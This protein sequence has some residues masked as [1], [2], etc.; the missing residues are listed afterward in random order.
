[1]DLQLDQDEAGQ[2]IRVRGNRIDAAG[3]VTF[4]DRVLTLVEGGPGR[5]MLDLSSI[6]FLDSSGLGALVAIRRML[7]D[8]ALELGAPTPPV[9]RVLRLTRMDMVFAIHPAPVGP[10][11]HGE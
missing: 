5:V 3:A 10:A 2:V 7:G 4:K 1:M 6:E 9:M 11:T 8:R